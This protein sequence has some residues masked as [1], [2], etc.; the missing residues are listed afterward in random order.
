MKRDEA[1]T[2]LCQFIKKDN[3]LKHNLA[4]EVVMRMQCRALAKNSDFRDE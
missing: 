1:Y 3:M 4:S 2:L